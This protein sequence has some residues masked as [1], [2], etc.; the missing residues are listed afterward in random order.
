MNRGLR[1]SGLKVRY[2][3]F[4]EKDVCMLSGRIRDLSCYGYRFPADEKLRQNERE[5]GK[6]VVKK[7]AL[8][9]FKA[10]PHNST[11]TSS[12]LIFRLFPR[13]NRGC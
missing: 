9:V 5:E 3:R 6:G 4:L 13:R 11:R 2:Y 10:I 7:L 8:R 1:R 12:R